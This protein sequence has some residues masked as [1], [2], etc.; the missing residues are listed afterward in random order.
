MEIKNNKIFIGTVVL[1][2]IF[3][4]IGS[5]SALSWNK[6][7]TTNMRLDDEGNLDLAGNYSTSNYG[8]FGWLGSLGSRITGLFVV[9]INASGNV[10]VSGD[11]YT[12]GDVGVGTQNTSATLDVAGKIKISDDAYSAEEGMLR[13][14]GNQFSGYNGTDWVAISAGAG[15][16]SPWTQ[17]ENGT[18]YYNDG[19]IGIGTIS[20]STKL[21]VGGDANVTGTLYA[22]NISS[23]SPLQLQTNGTTRIYVND[24]TGNV[25]IGTNAPSELLDLAGNSKMR[26]IRIP[27]SDAL[28]DADGSATN[29]TGNSSIVDGQN[30]TAFN[31]TDNICTDNLF[32]PAYVFIHSYNSSL[33]QTLCNLT[34]VANVTNSTWVDLIGNVTNLS[35]TYSEVNSSSAWVYVDNDSSGTYTDGEEIWVDNG[36]L[37]YDFESTDTTNLLYHKSNLLRWQDDIVL[38]GHYENGSLVLSN[39]YGDDDVAWEDLVVA[40]SIL[41]AGAAIAGAI[42]SSSGT[43]FTKPVDFENPVDFKDDVTLN[44]EPGAVLFMDAISQIDGDALDFY[45]DNLATRLG[46]GTNNPQATLHLSAT[47]GLADGT[48]RVDGASTFNGQTT[49]NDYALFYDLLSANGRV[50]LNNDTYAYMNFTID[51]DAQF[52]MEN[53]HSGSIPFIAGDKELIENNS[54][55]YWNAED[56]ELGV[57]TNGTWAPLTVEGNI[58][59]QPAVPY[60]MGYV[61]DNTR[62]SAAQD[63]FVLGKYAY[64]ASPGYNGI[65]VVDIADPTNPIVVGS[66]QNNAHLNDA[67]GIFV[68][69][70][71][72]YVTASGNDTL[73]IVD[74][75]DPFDPLLVGWAYKASIYGDIADVYVQGKYAYIVSNTGSSF[76][77]IDIGNPFSPVEVGG[78]VDAE[79]TGV[80]SVYVQGDYAYVTVGEGSRAKVHVIDIIGATNPSI[81][82]TYEN[83]LYAQ[84]AKDIYVSGNL[85]YVAVSE[86]DCLTILNVSSAYDPTYR[87]SLCDS[88]YLDGAHSVQLISDY[89]IVT[90]SEGDTIS[91][92]DTGDLD[93]LEITKSFADATNLNGAVGFDVSGKY[94]YVAAANANTLNVISISGV[95]AISAKVGSIES[96]N[97]HVTDNARINGN[98]YTGGLNVRDEA[99][100]QRDINVNGDVLPGADRIWNLG[101]K[102]NRWNNL[103][104]N[105]TIVFNATPD[106]SDPANESVLHAFIML[107]NSQNARGFR[108]GVYD[109]ILDAD[110]LDGQSDVDEEEWSP[111]TSDQNYVN[112]DGTVF[113]NYQGIG[114]GSRPSFTTPIMDAIDVAGGRLRKMG[115]LSD[116][117]CDSQASEYS[118]SC[119]LGGANDVVVAGNKMYVAGINDGG[120]Q[121]V[122]TRHPSGIKYT[123]LVDNPSVS[124]IFQGMTD[125]KLFGT[126]IVV[127]SSEEEGSLVI[128][129]TYDNTILA[130]INDSQC[131]EIE[132]NDGDEYDSCSLTHPNSVEMKGKNLYVASNDGLQI[133]STESLGIGILEPVSNI[134]AT[135]SNHLNGLNDILIDYDRA[136]VTSEDD[137]SVV[138]IDITDVKKPTVMG[139]LQDNVFTKFKKP[140]KIVK[141]KKSGAYAVLSAEENAITLLKPNLT[142]Q[143]SDLWFTEE[144]SMDN[145]ECDALSDNE[146]GCAMYNPVDIQAVDSYIM[147]ISDAED[148]DSDGND[149]DGITI[150]NA[151]VNSTALDWVG[152]FRDSNDTLLDNPT[153]ITS[154]GRYVYVTSNESGGG[155]QV[156]SF[157]AA[158]LP[159][160]DIGS[161]EIEEL[162]VR[163][164]TYI[165]GEV[166]VAGFI[167]GEGIYSAGDFAV[168]SNTSNSI[169]GTLS[170]G[171]TYDAE[172]FGDYAFY[173][174]GNTNI[175]GSINLTEGNS[176][177][178]GGAGGISING[179]GIDLNFA[180]GSVL[181]ADADGQ[182]SNDSSDFNWN[183]TSNELSIN[184]S[185]IVDGTAK[186]DILTFSD[187]S[188][189]MMAAMPNGLTRQI[190]TAKYNQGNALALTENHVGIFFSPDGTKLYSVDDGFN[191]IY[192]YDITTPWNISTID[193]IQSKDISAQTTDLSGMFISFDGTKVY[194]TD[195]Q[196]TNESILRYD[197]STP[198]NISTMSYVQTKVVASEIQNPAGVYFSPDGK[199][200]FALDQQGQDVT[201]YNLATAWDLDTVNTSQV[202]SIST[203]SGTATGFHF[204]YDGKAFY[205]VGSSSGNVAQYDLSTAWDISTAYYTKELNISTGYN[206]IYVGPAGTKMYLL[207]N[208]IGTVDYVYEYY[209]GLE[210]GGSII[211]S[212]DTLNVEGNINVTGNHTGNVTVEG[213]LGVGVTPTTKLH[214]KSDGLF[215]DVFVIESSNGS[216][217][218]MEFAEDGDGAGGFDLYNGS[219]AG[220]DYRTSIRAGT[221][222][223]FK[224]NLG[225]G[226]NTPS[227][228]LEVVGN[229]TIVGDLNVTGVSYLGDAIIDSDNIT[230]NNILSKDGNL[231][232]NNTLY[233]NEN[234]NVGIGTDSPLQKLHVM[235][236]GNSSWTG[237]NHGIL[238][239]DETGPR[240]IF[241]ETEAGT[242]NK[243]MVLV[244]ADNLMRFASINDAGTSWENQYILTANRNGN[245]GIGRSNPITELD[246]Q[247]S[248]LIRGSVSVEDSFNV[249][250]ADFYVD[251]S[252]NVSIGT[253][254]YSSSK[255]TITT[256]NSGDSLLKFNTPR[257]WEF[258]Q[259]NGGAGTALRLRNTVGVS[260]I[261]YID[262]NGSTRFRSVDGALTT[263]TIN[264]ANQR[265]GIGTISPQNT[266]NVVGDLNVTGTSYLGDVTLTSDNI[267]VNNIIPR[268]NE[269]VNVRGNLEVNSPD[270]DGQYIG[271]FLDSGDSWE[272]EN[273][274]QSWDVTINETSYWYESA[275]SADGKYMLITSTGSPYREYLSTDYGQTWTDLNITEGDGGQGVAMSADGKY[276][277]IT[278]YGGNITVSS[279]YGQT[280]TDKDSTRDW[281][282][283]AMSADGRYQ[284]AVAFLEN[285]FVSEDYGETWTEKN[286]TPTNWE[287]FAISAD[288]RYQITADYGG[289]IYLSTDFGQSWTAK[290]SNRNWAAF[291]MSAD[292]KYITGTVSGGN[293]YTSDD[294]GQTW[295]ARGS[296]GTWWDV[297]MT[298]EGR[299]QIAGTNSS[300]YLSTN[301][302]V[303]WTVIKEGQDWKGIAMSGDGKYVLANALNDKVYISVADSVMP[304]GKVGVGINSPTT[305]L[306]I[307]DDSNSQALRIY[308]NTSANLQETGIIFDVSQGQPTLNY[309]KGGIFF[310]RDDSAG[311]WGKGNMIFAVD[312]ASDSGTVNKADEKMRIDVTGNV[313]IGTSSPTSKLEVNGDV[314]I[315]GGDLIVGETDLFVDATTGKV[316]IGKNDPQYPFEVVGSLYSMTMRLADT[317]ADT[318]TKNAGF[319]LSHYSNSEQDVYGVGLTSS[320]TENTMNYGGGSA[321]FNAVNKHT[322]WTATTPTSLYG[323]N[324]MIIQNA[325][326]TINTNL[327]VNDDFVVNNSDLYVNTTSGSVGI[328]TSSPTDKLHVVSN[329]V[330]FETESAGDT[331]T[332]ELKENSY[333]DKAGFIFSTGGTGDAN[334]FQLATITGG[335]GTDPSLNAKLT[336][337]GSSGKVGIGTE[338][339]SSKLE[340]NGNV[341]LNNTLY[342]NESGNVGIGV[343]APANVLH[344][345]SA[346]PYV[347][348]Q[349]SESSYS[350][351]R[352]KLLFTGT[353]GGVPRTDMQFVTGILGSLRYGIAYGPNETEIFSVQGNT[354]RV[355]IGTTDPSLTLHVNQSGE[356]NTVRI[357]DA[358][359]TCN[360]DPDSGSLVTSCSSDEK[361][362]E[363]I[364]NTTSALEDFEDIEIKDYVVKASGKNTTGVI[365][366][367]INKTHPELVED[368]NGTLFVEQPNP[369][370]LLKAIQ[371]LKERLDS[372]VGGNYTITGK[373][374]FYKDMI[375]TATVKVNETFVEIE[376]ENN[377]SN[378]P[379]VTVTPLDFIDGQYRVTKKSINGFVI[380]LQKTQEQDINFD[381]H[382]F[383]VEGGE[384]NNVTITN[385]TEEVNGTQTNE[386]NLTT[387]LNVTEEVNET[388]ANGTSN[389]T[390]EENPTE[391]VIEKINQT[392][393]DTPEEDST[394]VSVVVNVT[395]KVTE[396]N[397]SIEEPTNDTIDEP[398]EESVNQTE[399]SV[400]ERSVVQENVD[401]PAEIIEE[402]LVAEEKLETI[403]ETSDE[404]SPPEPVPEASESGSSDEGSESGSSPITGGVIGTENREG[405]LIK[406]I[407]WVSNI[408]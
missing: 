369:W 353:G 374:V 45:W 350:A 162:A 104:L 1:M 329:D 405:V 404:G 205:V 34:S 131:D 380:E 284:S 290:E 69:G 129:D 108:I 303:N 324:S 389:E 321:Q 349:D 23:N 135:P 18:V 196:D 64:V 399:E 348:I 386:T 294:Y 194:V 93:S 367:E 319:V 27:S 292:G 102:N 231:S 220:A 118:D 20:P 270:A 325:N 273:V 70:R 133:M 189:Q 29:E 58:G 203:H 297:D 283:V 37:I 307:E 44:Q 116:D 141:E 226:T 233:I 235:A 347:Y 32:F 56:S 343:S 363:D 364:K 390:P 204:N 41:A 179:S 332:F 113:V 164:D 125:M 385:L 215:S 165:E 361:L 398:V 225:V 155:I 280:W 112:E 182:I 218:L 85:A 362:K 257:A 167:R 109:A 157:N 328:G 151:I 397:I 253:T 377:Y 74:I 200:M 101:S 313:G 375:G 121:P 298:N 222:S 395:E 191:G 252:G 279:D 50:N 24:S 276:M 53:L 30:F 289:Q 336:I 366:Q 197:L 241:E 38:T 322:F 331:M 142:A 9:D 206:D 161:A 96:S 158:N 128:L 31:S 184:G 172:D 185:L 372:L 14:A 310:E 115:S 309:S 195:Y 60:P 237:Q 63:V 49:F 12:G 396:P 371:E 384:E 312:N 160:A 4:I 278:M 402:V 239:T 291:A 274:G 300:L 140:K 244:Y 123:E 221:D 306:D 342:V 219:T 67:S 243:T 22:G 368:V 207:E 15:T 370:K 5:A 247:G 211:P 152:T 17:N 94:A 356:G 99:Y 105:G 91:I 305:R 143:D 95:D 382:A 68:S 271:R 401:E 84:G 117:D 275:M 159:V 388:I 173:V 57:G 272:V 183:W 251:A 223:F 394:N 285:I 308:R 318:T 3:S 263:M 315:S 62:L 122:L 400:E 261:F 326:V 19:N 232:L 137:D 267:T 138:M 2:L 59:Q 208:V 80:N 47:D 153:S 156:L 408:F 111:D 126:N 163:G 262:T 302:G 216:Y 16:A 98:L 327:N 127:S 352:A 199:K 82:G 86:I 106:T 144:D 188:T 71:Y 301:Y 103:Y 83:A 268:D 338:S 379:I 147:V 359:G 234:G 171:T 256:T 383:A 148:Q 311:G 337:L 351:T 373:A 132:A 304:A 187:N 265:V 177:F 149:N 229:T 42:M 130:Q 75:S 46:L 33:N 114:Y 36:N 378:V 201:E 175:N 287:G 391:E 259:E 335:G 61:Q 248:A 176:I 193:Y 192:E 39:S 403:S 258:Q 76:K 250:G 269:T 124:S 87:A 65:A 254:D 240:L 81:V 227:S 341:N 333:G 358:D 214:V 52:K 202:F 407:N 255:L 209:L 89:A 323:T 186:M 40:G 145:D 170:V 97:L 286:Y 6:N 376:F 354:G 28:I 48:M 78:I 288:G 90:G 26:G 180:S 346:D 210:F 66:E 295:T 150:F 242:D 54:A 357:Q 73:G 345:K 7:G 55:L 344:I 330:K 314:N 51:E 139:W 320:S 293:L 246:V 212:G 72:A 264:Q 136:I 334:K 35:A 79:L 174:N 387:P 355:G 299:I 236:S 8:F 13:Y 146:Q 43:T 282:N 296:S 88:T 381:W 360:L 190:T 166:D 181:F 266:L 198:W 365:A 228:K 134:P 249:T 217:N 77:I 340:V 110:P 281:S 119:Y 213:Y 260:K 169:G 25:G 100:F 406:F 277:T 238:M 10:N 245:V 120:I 178:I 92:I 392:I 393:N 107:D 316:G 168:E 11:I 317:T 339:P 224:D 21:G 154:F 230:I